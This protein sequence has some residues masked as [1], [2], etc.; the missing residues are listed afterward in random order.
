MKYKKNT[1]FMNLITMVPIWLPFIPTVFV[2]ILFY[3]YMRICFPIYGL[4]MVKRSEYIQVLDRN[5]LKYLTWYEKL[6]CMYCGYMNGV[7]R[8]M[9]EVAGRTESYWC[10]I[11]H[12][13]KP[14]FKT[15]EHQTRQS[16]IAFN[17]K[18]SFEKE[19]KK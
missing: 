14:N 17:D 11:M 4:E 18:Q 9:K 13:K 6:G 12:E 5:K 8:W 1:P 15:Q 2:D 16:F 19:Y 7:L 10:G 3:L